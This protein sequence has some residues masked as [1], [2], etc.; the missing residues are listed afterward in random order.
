MINRQIIPQTTEYQLA[1][2]TCKN[3]T[4]LEHLR[5]KIQRTCSKQYG[6]ILDILRV[7]NVKSRKVSIYNGNI[8]VDCTIEVDHLFPQVG[9]M[10]NGTVKQI[11]PQGLIILVKDCMKVFIP[12]SNTQNTQIKPEQIVEFKI[13]QT[14]FQKGKF[15]CIGQLIQSVHNPTS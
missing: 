11:F 14:R 5:K 1:T 13:V 6:F 8:I 2:E 10:L 4:L 12:Y 9:Q 15:D 3:E 7:V